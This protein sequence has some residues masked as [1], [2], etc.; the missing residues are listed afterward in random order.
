MGHQKRP[1]SEISLGLCNILYITLMLLLIRDRTIPE[2]LREDK[3][4]SLIPN[5]SNKYLQQNYTKNESGSYILNDKI[6]EA[7]DYDLF[8]SFMNRYYNPSQGFTIL[9]IEEPEAH[10]HPALQ[11]LLYGEVLHKSTTSVIFTTHSTH[12]T[13]IAPLNSIVHFYQNDKEET[14]IKS[15][16]QLTL[17]DKDRNDL[18]RYLDT[19]RSELFLSAGVILVEGIAEEYLIPRF[20]EL[21]GLSL[22]Y[23]QISVCNVNSNHFTPY[24]KLLNELNI[25]WCVITDGDYYEEEVDSKDNNLTKKVF[26]KKSTNGSKKKYAGFGIASKTLS[27][28]GIKRTDSTLSKRKFFKNHGLFVGKYTLE[29]DIME[30]GGDVENEIIKSVFADIKPGGDRQQ[31][32]FEKEIDSGN[33]WNAL[34]KIENTV[35]KG[36]FAQRLASECTAEQIP[37]YVKES[38]NY[39]VKK[40]ER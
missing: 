25:P 30:K 6:N 32:N 2:I 5:D 22:D 40:V 34:N 9:A 23:N 31:A 13:S 18:Q 17:T 38:I 24:V 37:E 29:V 28:I 27:S 15:S 7:V 16:H 11:R 39:L 26:H 10:L 20:A 12:I 3:F 19:K 1:V 4:N 35:G 21:Q 8:Y 33:Y 36:R 14:E